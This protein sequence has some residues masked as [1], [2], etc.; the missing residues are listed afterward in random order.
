MEL[1][2]IIL[3]KRPERFARFL[4]ASQTLLDPLEPSLAQIETATPHDIRFIFR[5]LH[6]L[7]GNARSFG[8]RQLSELTHEAEQTLVGRNWELLRRTYQSLYEV[9]KQYGRVL[10][11][12][13]G[14]NREADHI[15]LDQRLLEQHFLNGGRSASLEDLILAQTFSSA[16]QL[17]TEVFSDVQRMAEDLGKEKPGLHL[18]ADGIYF[19]RSTEELITHALGHLFRNALDHG[20]ETAS[21]RKSR[22]KKSF[23]CITVEMEPQNG[24][25]LIRCS[26]DG[27]G[28]D[29]GSIR[30]RALARELIQ[31]DEI[32]SE[33][34]VEELIFSS[35]FSTR[36][37]ANLVSGR[38]VGLDA[39]R[40]FLHEIQ[41]EIR[42]IVRSKDLDRQLWT[43]AFELS[44]PRGTWL[45]RHAS[46]RTQEAS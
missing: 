12:R 10:Q 8:L 45:A 5:N 37:Q 38:G 11:E 4:K 1:V 16:Q 30:T 9:L 2:Q 42:L 35:G 36:R 14:W 46:V 13:M 18:M 17:I 33:E 28:L 26:D 25:L 23:G 32:L 39:V 6:T 43:F 44:L 15:M 34:R 40:G 29:V 31:S 22:G 41:G 19:P 24:W 7:K 20:L 27:R 21:E 3:A